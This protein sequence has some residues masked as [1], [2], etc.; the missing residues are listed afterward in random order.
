M[1]RRLANGLDFAPLDV[2]LN[3]PGADNPRGNA[4]A[5]AYVDTEPFLSVSIDGNSKG[6]LRDSW[7]GAGLADT[8]ALHTVLA[9]KGGACCARLRPAAVF[10]P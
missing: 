3:F 2:G 7:G 6:E 9:V 8:S 4:A 5:Y 1:L 10:D